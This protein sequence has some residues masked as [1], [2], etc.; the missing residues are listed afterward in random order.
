MSC[1]VTVAISRAKPGIQKYLTLME[2][3]DQIDV[4]TDMAFQRIYNGFYRVRQRQRDWYEAYYSLMEQR[5]GSKPKFAE[6]LDHLHRV[7]NRFEPSFASKLV[8]TLDPAR[9]VWD[10]HV[11]RNIGQEAP[12]YHSRTKIED[13]KYCY[14]QIENWYQRFLASA[15]GTDWVGIFNEQV[16]E[17][18]RLTDL[19]KVDFILW[20]M[21]D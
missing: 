2:Q 21:R 9:P 17:S 11:L 5:K 8:A 6:I 4:S 3:L 15:Q 10:V 14:S 19:K 1:D 12:A 16:Q 20:Q 18:A 7:T 13:A